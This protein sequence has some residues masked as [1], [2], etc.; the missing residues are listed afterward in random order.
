M[1]HKTVEFQQFDLLFR[2]QPIRAQ[3]FSSMSRGGRGVPFSQS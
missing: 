3:I 1:Y 2:A